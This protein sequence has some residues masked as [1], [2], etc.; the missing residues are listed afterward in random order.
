[1]SEMS[2]ASD[3]FRIRIWG[4]RGSL[5]VSGP[6][7][8]TYGGNTICIEMQCGP[9]RL[10]FD[11]GSGILPAGKAFKAEDVA[12]CDLFFSHCHYDHI[13]GLP[14][15]AP[16]FCPRSSVT[17]WSGHLN[18]QRSTKAI[19]ADF[20]CPPW[21]PVTPD[22]FRADI[23]YQDFKAEDDLHPRPGITIKTGS[24]NH[25]GGAIGYRVEFGGRSV[26][27]ITDTEHTPG[28]FDPSVQRLIK[29]CDL[30]FYDSHL[31]DSEMEEY[32]DF[33]HSSWQQAIRLAKDGGAKQVGFIH[34]ATWRQDAE[35]DALAIE[36]K[37]EFAGSFFAKDGQII[38]L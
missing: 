25:T 7:F 10:I 23:T 13:V 16:L 11:A 8:V 9:H 26:A 18:G 24:L 33:G 29:D 38:D 6:E 1:M 21:F 35:I 32:K 12:E 22:V 34:H 36:A 19:V 27:V 30:F 37:A 2:T 15:F 14:F 4:T 20:V 28:H 31:L 5:P 3:S 17:M